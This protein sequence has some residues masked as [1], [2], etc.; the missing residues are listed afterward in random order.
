M[1]FFQN[2]YPKRKPTANLLKEAPPG[3]D[4]DCTFLRFTASAFPS[5]AL[6]KILTSQRCFHS[7]NRLSKKA[8]ENVSSPRTPRMS[9][10]DHFAI[11]S[12]L[13]H[14]LRGFS[15]KQQ[16]FHLKRSTY[17]FSSPSTWRH[18]TSPNFFYNPNAA[19]KPKA[20]LY[21]PFSLNDKNSFLLFTK[22][23]ILPG[24]RHSSTAVGRFPLTTDTDFQRNKNFARHREHEPHFLLTLQAKT[25]DC[26][27]SLCEKTDHTRVV[28]LIS[29]LLFAKSSPFSGKSRLV[30][31]PS[32]RASFSPPRSAE[33]DEALPY[34]IAQFS[35]AGIRSFPLLTPPTDESS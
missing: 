29:P 30:F 22:A 35:T 26:L 32:S 2:P 21:K 18:S 19:R 8:E 34:S 9:C 15:R 20:S 10:W 1:Q 14:N 12:Y 25:V 27:L 23:I 4:K 3:A 17:F 11:Q 6:I 16:G 13:L 33:R 31:P 5:Y 7:R 28:F 24:V